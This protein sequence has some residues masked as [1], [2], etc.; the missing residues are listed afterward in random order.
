MESKTTEQPSQRLRDLLQKANPVVDSEP[1]VFCRLHNTD[2]SDDS[3]AIAWFAEKEGANAIFRISDAVRLNLDFQHQWAR[4]TLT[5]HSDLADVGFLAVLLPPL[6]QAGISVN[7]V[8]A[9]Y[10]DY[11]FVPWDRQAQALQILQ[12]TCA[13]FS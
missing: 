7:A 1:H 11:L 9:F 8:S 12:E 5:V 13:K 10:H 2:T 3:C 4:I 6:A